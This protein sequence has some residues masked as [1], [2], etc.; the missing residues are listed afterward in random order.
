M[1]VLQVGV[2]QRVLGADVSARCRGG[3]TGQRSG[4]SERTPA[5]GGT[6]CET[7][8]QVSAMEEVRGGR[9]L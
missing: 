9:P 7:Y 5:V 1:Q 6:G 2:A 8:S 3:R 4:V